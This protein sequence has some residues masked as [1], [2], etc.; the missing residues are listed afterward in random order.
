MNLNYLKLFQLKTSKMLSTLRNTTDRTTTNCTTTTDEK[1]PVAGQTVD[2]MQPKID[3]FRAWFNKITIGGYSDDNICEEKYDQ[4]QDFCKLCEV[5]GSEYFN[6]QNKRVQN[7]IY[8][9]SIKE[10]FGIIDRTSPISI[11]TRFNQQD[12]KFND[13]AITI[14]LNNAIHTGDCIGVLKVLEEA[15]LK[16]NDV[17]CI[18]TEVV[19]PDFPHNLIRFE[20]D[21]IYDSIINLIIM[22]DEL[23]DRHSNIKQFIRNNYFGLFG[24]SDDQKDV[25]DKIKTIKSCY[26]EIFTVDEFEQS[27]SKKL[28]DNRPEDNNIF[29]FQEDI[30]NAILTGDYNVL[31][32]L[33]NNLSSGP[34]ISDTI[35]LVMDLKFIAIAIGDARSLAIID[36][37]IPECLIP[38]FEHIALAKGKQLASIDIDTQNRPGA[39][40]PLTQ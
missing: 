31:E 8:N 10:H 28:Q 18:Y 11:N 14:K 34:K 6:K 39:I 21:K 33:I 36:E 1:L 12:I 40:S 4:F 17:V 25:V 2:V 7:M 32:L 20:F 23:Y 26:P 16:I 19:D 3:Q 24:L 27:V 30:E 35:K 13:M 22:F 29:N 5:V 15:S 38:R 9:N 37:L